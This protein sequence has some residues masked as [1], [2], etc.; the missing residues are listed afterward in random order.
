MAFLRS[1]F[2]LIEVVLFSS[3]LAAV[4]WWLTSLYYLERVQGAHVFLDVGANHYKSENNTYYLET[5]L[6]WSGVAVDAQP[7]FGPDY[8]RYRP[9]TRYVA[10]FAADKDDEFTQRE[11]APGEATTVPT[12]TLNTVLN[13][14]EI[15]GLDLLSMDTPSE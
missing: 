4:S 15:H 2:T 1:R 8:A 12:T 5:A 11:L 9:R 10:M 6:G 7:D 13:Q 14:A 3:G